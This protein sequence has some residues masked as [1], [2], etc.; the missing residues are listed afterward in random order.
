MSC[1]C[2]VYGC[3]FASALRQSIQMMEEGLRHLEPSRSSTMIGTNNPASIAATE[4]V[5]ERK[6]RW[7]IRTAK[8]LFAPSTSQGHGGSSH[9]TM[10]NGTSSHS[11]TASNSSPPRTL[12]SIEAKAVLQKITFLNLFLANSNFLASVGCFL[13]AALPSQVFAM[14]VLSKILCFLL[15]ITIPCELQMAMLCNLYTEIRRRKMKSH[16]HAQSTSLV[17]QAMQIRQKV[18]AHPVKPSSTPS[19]PP[20]AYLPSI[21]V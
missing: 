5:T 14:S 18:L 11:S 7:S 6:S 20:P 8:G 10:S 17:S 2:L 12:T 4:E 3:S 9:G 19:S 21:Q 16:F 1:T 13:L 15:L